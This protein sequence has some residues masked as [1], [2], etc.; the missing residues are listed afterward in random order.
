MQRG[1][2]KADLLANTQRQIRARA[3]AIAVW[4]TARGFYDGK[5]A[6]GN[7]QRR[8]CERESAKGNNVEDNRWKKIKRRLRL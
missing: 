6:K 1:L 7:L 4:G 5:S 8:I 3:D 2:R